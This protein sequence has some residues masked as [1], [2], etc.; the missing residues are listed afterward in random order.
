MELAQ[1]AHIAARPAAHRFEHEDYQ[2]YQKFNSNGPAL[3]PEIKQEM[4]RNVSIERH[5][6]SY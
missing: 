6:I 5:G 1:R 2:L 4:T 3:R